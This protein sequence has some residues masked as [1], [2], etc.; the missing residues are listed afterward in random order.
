MELEKKCY[1]LRLC[2]GLGDRDELV[3]FLN[4]FK[5]ITD[6]M[7]SR[8]V[9]K[10]ADAEKRVELDKHYRTIMTVYERCTN[11]M[12]T[13]RRHKVTLFFFLLDFVPSMREWLFDS[14]ERPHVHNREAARKW[15]DYMLH[16]LVVELLS[17][18]N[19]ERF[20]DKVL[21]SYYFHVV[22]KEAQ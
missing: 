9:K 1:I 17:S 8:L 20:T 21:G 11:G 7:L 12:R 15:V 13:K 18:T 5:R 6:E 3:E 2:L 19:A 10:H 22:G 14:P 4:D 16:P